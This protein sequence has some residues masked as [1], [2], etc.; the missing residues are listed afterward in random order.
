MCLNE[1]IAYLSYVLF[2]AHFLWP[3]KEINQLNLFPH[4]SVLYRLISIYQPSDSFHRSLKVASLIFLLSGDSVDDSKVCG[5]K[6]FISISFF[7]VLG[8]QTKALNMLS[9][10]CA[11]YIHTQPSDPSP[12]A[13]C[14][15]P[16]QVSA[17]G[18]LFV[19]MTQIK[20]I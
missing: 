3:H 2:Q 18:N 13:L 14:P 10:C 11:T 8:I 16:F 4:T 7:L 9:H 15:V 6:M 5:L 17:E 20:P 19:F 12:P 1:K